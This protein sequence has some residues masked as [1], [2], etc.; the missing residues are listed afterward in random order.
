MADYANPGLL[1]EPRDLHAALGGFQVIDT[2]PAERFAGGRIPGAVH[3][4]LWALSLMDTDPA[5]LRAFL[6][7]VS[8]YINTRGIDP[9][10]PVVVY[11]AEESGIRAARAFWFL[12]YFGHPN[13][14]VLNGGF[15]AWQAAG[16]PV[17][18]G[19]GRT[20]P[21]GKWP[22]DGSTPRREDVIA[23]WRDVMAG[24]DPRSARERVAILDTRTEGEHRGTLVR[25]KR[26]GAIPGSIHVE[27]KATLAADG[28]FRPAS[29]LRRLY[30]SNGITPEREVITYCQGGYRAAHGYLALRLLGY[31]RVKNYISSWGEWGNRDDLPAV[32]PPT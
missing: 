9:K 27:W 10:R 18:T 12:E 26:G 14:R 5:P 19:A 20:P 7:T 32:T 28:R 1:I 17:E 15:R 30:E 13:V 31:P 22:D 29:E 4:E 11:E 25:A 8:H 23:G 16:L 21:S 2:S 6:S 3:L 24:I